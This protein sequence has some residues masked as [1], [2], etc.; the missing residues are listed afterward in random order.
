MNGYKAKRKAIQNV[1]WIH[2]RGVPWQFNRKTY[3]SQNHGR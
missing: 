1:E 3:N 2:R